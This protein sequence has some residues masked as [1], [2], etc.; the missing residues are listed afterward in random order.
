MKQFLI[1][2]ISLLLFSSYA[3][4]KCQGE[5]GRFE[6]VTTDQY[7]DRLTGLIWYRCPRIMENTSCF[8]FY[9]HMTFSEALAVAQHYS[10]DTEKWRLPNIKELVSIMDY[11]CGSWQPHIIEPLMP[12]GAYDFWSA[13]PNNHPHKVSAWIMSLNGVVKKMDYFSRPMDEASVFLVR[14]PINDTERK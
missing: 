4:A 2:A 1:L 11:D 5:E 12:F 7:F 10:N 3:L 6:L 8:N 13:T 14:E 9:N